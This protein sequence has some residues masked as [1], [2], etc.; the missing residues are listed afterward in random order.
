MYEEKT[1]NLYFEQQGTTL[2]IGTLKF[3]IRFVFDIDHVTNK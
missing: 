2:K 3:C 1:V